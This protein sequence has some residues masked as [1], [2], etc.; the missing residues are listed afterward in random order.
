MKQATY[1]QLWRS[2]PNESEMSKRIE[3][4][5]QQCRSIHSLIAMLEDNNVFLTAQRQDQR[6][7]FELELLYASMQTVNDVTILCE[8][9]FPR[10]GGNV[11]KVSVRT[12]EPLIIPLALALLEN[13]LKTGAVDRT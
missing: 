4:L 13:L 1:L 6:G 2:I 3:G 7:H 12:I 10:G 11:C 8:F 9:T 5:C